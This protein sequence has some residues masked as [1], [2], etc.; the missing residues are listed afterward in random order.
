L[1]REELSESLRSAGGTGLRIASQIGQQAKPIVVSIAVIVCVSAVVCV[2]IVALKSSRPSV[3]AAPLRQ[4]S[5]GGD[6]AR[7]VASSLLRAAV[8]RL[9]TQVVMRQ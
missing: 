5:F 3:A 9:V 6:L 4:P 8:R 7:A 2:A 1:R